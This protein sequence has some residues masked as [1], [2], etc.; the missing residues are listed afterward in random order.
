MVRVDHHPWGS[1]ETCNA[2]PST[3][4]KRSNADP[5]RLEVV[6]TPRRPTRHR[7]DRDGRIAVRGLRKCADPRPIRLDVWA[8]SVDVYTRPGTRSDDPGAGPIGLI[9]P[10]LDALKTVHYDL[11]AYSFLVTDWQ[12][13]W[14]LKGSAPEGYAING[15]KCESTDGEWTFRGSSTVRA[16]IPSS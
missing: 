1:H 8:R 4:S 12:V 6:A 5:Q 15:I 16:S 14:S 7:R 2:H 11:G 3:G 13:G 10:I 9:A